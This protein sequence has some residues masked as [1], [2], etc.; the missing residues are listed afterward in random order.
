[1]NIIAQCISS[2]CCAPEANLL[3]PLLDVELDVDIERPDLF[4]VLHVVLALH[5]ATEQ[6][7]HTKLNTPQTL[8]WKI[9]FKNRRAVQN[10]K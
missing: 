8:V 7:H 2:L 9:C 1:M 4:D 3:N 5:R 6:Q 10:K